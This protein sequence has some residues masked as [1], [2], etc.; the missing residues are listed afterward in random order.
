[1]A[2]AKCTV[3]EAMKA[4]RGGL[5]GISAECII[6][7]KPCATM[8]NAKKMAC[9]GACTVAVNARKE[10]HKETGNT[11]EDLE[12]EARQTSGEHECSSSLDRA[13]QGKGKG[14]VVC[15]GNG[16]PCVC[17]GIC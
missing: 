4:A 8:P 5:L 11:Q 12:L 7:L 15:P 6:C 16:Q 13:L 3:A 2:G 14:D 1:M 17:N 10:F 9:G